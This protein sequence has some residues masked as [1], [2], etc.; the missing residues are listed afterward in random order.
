[1]GAPHMNKTTDAIM[2]E[3]QSWQ[4]RTTLWAIVKTDENDTH[5]KRCLSCRL[6]CRCVT[7]YL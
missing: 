2:T 3:S 7:E 5:G 6:L 4:K 1:M